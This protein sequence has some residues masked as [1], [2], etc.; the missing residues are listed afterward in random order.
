MQGQFILSQ[1]AHSE[2]LNGCSWSRTTSPLPPMDTH[3]HHHQHSESPQQAWRS[4]TLLQIYILDTT[5]LA[6]MV[7][8]E[9]CSFASR[10]AQRG[11]REFGTIECKLFIVC[12]DCW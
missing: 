5:N 12:F 6:L 8:S 10:M 3:G 1:S 4:E 11:A 7:Y 2:S 9:N